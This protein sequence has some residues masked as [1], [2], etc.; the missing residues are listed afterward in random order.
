MVGFVSD[1]EIAA[2]GGPAILVTSPRAEVSVLHNRLEGTSFALGQNEVA[3]VAGSAFLGAAA[4]IVA[5]SALLLGN[6]FRS[7]QQGDSPVIYAVG[8]RSPNITYVGNRSVCDNMPRRTNVLLLA[9]DVEQNVGSITAVSNTCREPQPVRPPEGPDILRDR[10]CDLIARENIVEPLRSRLAALVEQPMS[11]DELRSAVR[12]MTAGTDMPDETRR[13]LDEIIARPPAI[14]ET[15]RAI[16]AGLTQ[17]ET[18]RHETL[19]AFL[20]DRLAL[21]DFRKSIDDLDQRR[22][23]LEERL[24]ALEAAP[25]EVQISL[26]AMA[27]VAVTGMNLLSYRLARSGRGSDQ[28]TESGVF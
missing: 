3:V 24:R 6:R 7:R 10:L 9:G 18:Q 27:G 4:E 15:I 16:R 21:D 22:L 20:T 13:R 25:V 17:V 5:E 26:V 8:V 28:G 14:D 1:N 2:F 23:Q 12:D 11:A 19:N